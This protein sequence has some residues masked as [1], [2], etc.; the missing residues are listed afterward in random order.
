MEVKINLVDIGNGRWVCVPMEVSDYINS[1]RRENDDL[2]FKNSCLENEL[3]DIKWIPVSER[4]PEN[5]GVYLCS[6]DLGRYCYDTIGT[7]GFSNDLYSVD[8]YNFSGCEGKKGFYD[9]DSEVGYFEID[10]I[11]A[12][13]PL[14]EPYRMKGEE[15][16]QNNQ[17]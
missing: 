4:L 7:Y 1:L 5:D 15:D 12:W 9:Y 2:K 17:D 8:D 13:M 16:E 10:C 11:T 14:P 6:Y 3:N